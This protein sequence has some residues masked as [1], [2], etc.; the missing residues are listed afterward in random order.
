VVPVAPGVQLAG[1]AATRAGAAAT[2]LYFGGADFLVEQ[3]GPA[4]LRALAGSAPVN[5]VLLDYPGSGA[6]EGTPTLA[7]LKEHAIAAYDVVAARPDLA[8]AGVVVHGHSLG[9]FVAASLAD[10]RPVRGLVLQ[11]SA[12]TPG[13]WMRGFFRPSLFKWWARPAYP[14][15]RFTL[16]SALVGEDN[17]AR[18]QRY[19]GPLLVLVAADDITT[20]PTMSRALAAASATPDSLKRLAVLPGSGHDDVLTNRIRDGV[21]SLRAPRSGCVD[22]AVAPTTAPPQPTLALARE[23]VPNARQTRP[24][25]VA[26]LTRGLGWVVGVCGAALALVNMLASP[27]HVP[28]GIPTWNIAVAA[29][30][31]TP[32]A[33]VV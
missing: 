27:M 10:A 29:Q 6:S 16:D 7:T 28:S 23:T 32:V 3:H 4:T 19:R 21:R 12:T 2:V 22:E 24:H 25:S 5:V 18:V 1:L 11:S 8:P 15:L 17:V 20:A 30:S 13:D 31:A 33:A 9:S 14:F 26:V